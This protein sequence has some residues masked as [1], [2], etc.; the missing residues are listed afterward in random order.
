MKRTAILFLATS[1]SSISLL[2]RIFQTLGDALWA[3]TM[4]IC[5][6]AS[7]CFRFDFFEE[8]GRGNMTFRR[9]FVIF[10][11]FLSKKSKYHNYQFLPTGWSWSPIPNSRRGGTCETPQSLR[12]T[13][14]EKLCEMP[15]SNSTKFSP[16]V[17]S[18]LGLFSRTI[19]ML[20]VPY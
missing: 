3:M 9:R 19:T 6:L 11:H 13:R 8:C 12:D 14:L 1:K 7:A 5:C 15:C 4:R 16:S 10:E 18:I 17:L 2:I 20:P